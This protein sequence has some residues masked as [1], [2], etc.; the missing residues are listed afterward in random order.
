MNVNKAI[1]I[2]EKKDRGLSINEPLL[3]HAHEVLI[4]RYEQLREQN[5]RYALKLYG[6]GFEV[7]KE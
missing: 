5:E 7:D 2:I 4:R 6:T 1:A 3:R